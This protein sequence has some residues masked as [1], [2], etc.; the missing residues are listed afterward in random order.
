MKYDLDRSSHSVY[1]LNYHFVQCVKYR[2]KAFDF[3]EIIEELKS[4]T[5]GIAGNYWIEILSIETDLDHVHILFKSKP[6]IDLTKFINNWKSATSKVLRRKFK[7]QLKD[8]LWGD[9]FW[10]G[11][12]CLITTG[13]TTL[14]VLRKYVEDQG[15]KT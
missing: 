2:R 7:E 5:Q 11:S 15:E 3:P 10:S 9:A 13:Q 4:R 8:K 1:S 14:E 6:Q 12:Y